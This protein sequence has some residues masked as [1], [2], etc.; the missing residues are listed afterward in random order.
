MN[1]AENADIVVDLICF[2]TEDTRKMVEALRPT[3]CTHYLFCS[4]ITPRR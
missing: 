4:S 3:R 2:K 1:N